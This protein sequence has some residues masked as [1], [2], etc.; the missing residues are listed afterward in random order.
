M[1]PEADATPGWRAGLRRAAEAL[2]GLARCRLQLFAIELQEEKERFLWLLV[3]LAVIAV[4]GAAGGLVMLGLLTWLVYQ[5]AGLWGVA[6]VGLL[7]LAGAAWGLRSLLRTLREG[8]TPFHQ[9]VAEFRKDRAW[10][11]GND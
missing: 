6:G 11:T 8:P 4:L 9:T 5:L 10:L 2:W 3:R 7:C 1:D